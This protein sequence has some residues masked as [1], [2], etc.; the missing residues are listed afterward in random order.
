MGKPIEGRVRYDKDTDSFV[1]EIFS[2]GEWGMAQAAKC[3]RCEDDGDSEEP[4]YI[5]YSILQ[6]IILDAKRFGVNLS[7]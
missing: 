5:H 6:A 3:V 4:E 7:F 1:Y 2:D